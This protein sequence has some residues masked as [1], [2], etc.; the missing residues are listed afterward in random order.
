MQ[1]FSLN[2][3]TNNCYNYQQQQLQ[4]Q[5]I[6]NKHK[7][8][9]CYVKNNNYKNK[10][11]AEQKGE[12]SCMQTVPIWTQMKTSSNSSTTNFDYS[13][14]PVYESEEQQEQQ[15]F[16]ERKQQQHLSTSQQQQH[17]STSQRHQQQP[18]NLKQHDSYQQQQW[19]PCR[20]RKKL[21]DIRQEIWTCL[22]DPIIPFKI[23]T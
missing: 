22:F 4:Q 9:D 10:Q 7:T 8:P 20:N 2:T 23:S 13:S 19:Q 5:T 3:T 14:R 11:Q 17:C 21:T 1:K 16:F 18:L 6:R 12:I 15:R